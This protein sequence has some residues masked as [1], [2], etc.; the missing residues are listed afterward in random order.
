MAKDTMSRE[1]YLLGPD[2]GLIRIPKRITIGSE[3]GTDK[4]QSGWDVECL[5]NGAINIDDYLRIESKTV[6]GY[7]RVY[8]LDI[9]GDNLEGAWLT[10]ARV[11]EV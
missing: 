8:S 1:V 9:E 10:M 11:L 2:T 7:F 4:D 5:L 6:T 3:N